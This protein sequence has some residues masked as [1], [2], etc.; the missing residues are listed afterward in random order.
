MNDMTRDE[1]RELR[2]RDIAMAIDSGRGNEAEIAHD[3][4]SAA[5]EEGE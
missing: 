2:A 1:L 4:E 3:I 5:T